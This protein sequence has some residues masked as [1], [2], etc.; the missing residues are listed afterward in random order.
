MRGATYDFFL[1]PVERSGLRRLREELLSRARGKTLELGIGTGLNVAHYPPGVDLTGVE[2]DAAMA[3]KARSRGARVVAGDA[4]NLAFPDAS[5]DTVV[6]TLVFC[7]VDDWR[8][9]L[10]E[11]ARVLKPGGLFL[12]AEHVRPRGALG[13]A[14]D[15]LTPAWKLV[16]GGCRLDRDPEP[17]FSELG[18]SI[19]ERGA[20]WRGIGRW[21]VL[22]KAA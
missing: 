20:F 7:S 4:Q 11:A 21:W 12:M 15:L 16:A 17:F 1:R 2:P 14:A 9:G 13:V 6:A 19:A 8:A 3:E 18:L 5:F 22:R 10:R